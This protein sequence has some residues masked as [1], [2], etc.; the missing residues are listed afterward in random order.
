MPCLTQPLGYVTNSL[1]APAH[2]GNI[3]LMLEDGRR[4]EF[5]AT[6]HAHFDHG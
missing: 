2:A 4:I 3:S 1:S 5:S 6:A